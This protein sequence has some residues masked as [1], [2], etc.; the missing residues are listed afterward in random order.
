MARPQCPRQIDS[1]PGTLYFKPRA[2][3]L[4]QLQEVTLTFDEYEAIK[5]ADLKG[6]YHIQASKKMTISRQTFGRIIESARKKLADAIVNGKAIKIEGGIINMAQK[7]LFHCADCD[8]YWEAPFGTG[9]PEACPNCMSTDFRRADSNRG[10]GNS[11]K[12]ICRRHTV[13]KKAT[14]TKEDK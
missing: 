8:H 5:L 12:R 11:E 3:P 13:G 4:S 9:R 1:A 10:P 6:M 7:R 2:I 14:T